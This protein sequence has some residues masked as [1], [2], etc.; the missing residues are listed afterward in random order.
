MGGNKGG[1]P[2]AGTSG[3][4][5]TSKA[6]AEDQCRW[7]ARH[8]GGYETTLGAQTSRGCEGA[9]SR[10]QESCT[11]KDRCQETCEKGSGETGAEDCRQGLS[12]GTLRVRERR[13]QRFRRFVNVVVTL[14]REP[15]R[16]PLYETTRR[17]RVSRKPVTSAFMGSYPKSLEKRAT[18]AYCCTEPVS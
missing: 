10:R 6:K 16:V 2:E 14:R 17:L 12:R 3:Q 4:T 9:A 13:K 8:F 15:L 7:Q 1:I 18:R 11:A 5:G